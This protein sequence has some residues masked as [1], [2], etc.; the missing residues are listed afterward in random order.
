V[1]TAAFD[2][3]CLLRRERAFPARPSTVADFIADVASLGIGKIW[4]IVV[5]ISNA[6][7]RNGLADPTAGGW[8]SAAINEL[9]NVEA[10]RSWPAEQKQRFY[11]LPYDL[12]AFISE[13]E[14]E[15]DKAVRRAQNQAAAKRK[16]RSNGRQ[17]NGA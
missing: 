16:E 10:P 8:V 17:S 12:Q 9:A 3:W 15:R 7:T 6:H 1:T 4:P 5:A 14:A 13:R 11:A 2:N